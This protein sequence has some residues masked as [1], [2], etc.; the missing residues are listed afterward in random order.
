MKLFS[1]VLTTLLCINLQAASPLQP[2]ALTC[3]YIMNPLGIDTKL[4]R[5]GW[6]FTSNERNQFQ[7]AYEIIV[8]DN[9]QDIDKAAGNIWATGKINSA[10]NIQI[11]YAGKPL[12]SFIR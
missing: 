11:V 10:E 6:N 12:Q 8:S 3:E 2:A 5:L 9:V 7:L 1:W 4:P